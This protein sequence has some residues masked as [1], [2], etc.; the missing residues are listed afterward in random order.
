MSAATEIQPMFLV[1]DDGHD[2]DIQF[3]PNQFE[4]VT[5]YSNDLSDEYERAQEQLR[6]LRQQEEQIQQQAE[7]L[8]ELTRKEEEFNS[9][10]EEV[11]HKLE[12][13]LSQLDR[14]AA[15]A[16]KIADNCLETRE[17]FESH[18]NNINLLRPETWSRADRKGELTRALNYID[19][20]DRA[21]ENSMPLL[22][23]IGAEKKTGF[24]GFFQNRRSPSS[25]SSV[26]ETLHGGG[27]FLYWLKS[28]F[29]FSLP[30][31]GFA[32]IAA[33]V[34]LFF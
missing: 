25:G 24:R 12:T 3:E 7:E 16:R 2:L 26:G 10:R 23:M 34:M 8:E 1:E 28:G 32:V 4:A 5:P 33:V 14:E 13:Y 31:V 15:E 21:I 22:E 17:R 29:A 19:S 18:L 11:S 30:L 20:A 6:Q 9:G 27:D